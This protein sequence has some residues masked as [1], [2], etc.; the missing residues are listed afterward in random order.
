[1][2]DVAVVINHSNSSISQLPGVNEVS[3]LLD[4]MISSYMALP[5]G[6]QE[7]KHFHSLLP[8]WNIGSCNQ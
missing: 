6:V 1:M 4:H 8:T 7:D 3:K 2:P 5:A